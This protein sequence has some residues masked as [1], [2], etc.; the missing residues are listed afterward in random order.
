MIELNPHLQKMTRSV[1]S[2]VDWLGEVGGIF[3]AVQ[4]IGLLLLAI[5]QPW[6]WEK[7]LVRKLY[8]HQVPIKAANF[9][10]LPES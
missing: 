2:S 6:S 1:Y 9:K 7:Y 10:P 5:I 3:M 8:R 4:S